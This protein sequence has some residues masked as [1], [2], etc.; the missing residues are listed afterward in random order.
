MG[1]SDDED[2]QSKQ[3]QY[4]K[5][6]EDRL[7]FNNHAFVEAPI[8]LESSEDGSQSNGDQ[9]ESTDFGFWSEMQFLRGQIWI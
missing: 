4:I 1:S 8:A 7:V 9:S 6:V 3:N 5:Y 2:K